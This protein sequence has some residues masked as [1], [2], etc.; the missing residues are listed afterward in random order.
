MNLQ[1]KLWTIS[2]LDSQALDVL[3]A[4]ERVLKGG[5]VQV[6]ADKGGAGDDRVGEVGIA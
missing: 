2:K 5:A 6:G 4:D 3:V 1:W